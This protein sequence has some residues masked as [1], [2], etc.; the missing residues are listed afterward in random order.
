MD[1]LDDIEVGDKE[2]LCDRALAVGGALL[3]ESRD[4]V[5][6][7]VAASSSRLG[8]ELVAPICSGIFWVE[9][10]SWLYSVMYHA[11]SGRRIVCNCC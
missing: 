11:L 3:Q 2:R 7:M 5:S 8:S 1:G 9:V 4:I 6:R 10:S